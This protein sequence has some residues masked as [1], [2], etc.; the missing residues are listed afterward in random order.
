MKEE[1]SKQKK[2]KSHPIDLFVY[3]LIRSWCFC[4]KLHI[5]TKAI[6]ISIDS[7][8]FVHPPGGPIP[9]ACFV[10]AWWRKSHWVSSSRNQPYQ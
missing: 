8:T 10:F 4:A 6:I 5:S 9:A 7:S 1:S 3:L 2:M